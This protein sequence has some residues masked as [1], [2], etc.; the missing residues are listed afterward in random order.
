MHADPLDYHRL[1][2]AGIP[3]AI[4][5]TLQVLDFSICLASA[6]PCHAAWEAPPLRPL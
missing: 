3:E 1:D 4:A 2:N 5:S 6:L